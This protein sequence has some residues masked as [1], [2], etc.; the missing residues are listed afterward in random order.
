MRENQPQKY[1]YGETLS[2]EAPRP[3]AVVFEVLSNYL[4]PD[5]QDKAELHQTLN[6]V[7]KALADHDDQFLAALDRLEQ[8]T[9]ITNE[10]VLVLSVLFS[11]SET[12]GCDL[13]FLRQAVMTGNF[14]P[15]DIEDK[16]SKLNLDQGIV[17]YLRQTASKL[18]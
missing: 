11:V 14:N 3:T 16:L 18:N 15:K 4:N 10:D 7:Y 1:I 6:D 8:K 2:P 12:S 9:R 5:V 13:S 17:R